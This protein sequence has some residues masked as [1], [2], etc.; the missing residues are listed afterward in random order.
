MRGKGRKIIKIILL[1]IILIFIGRMI[2]GNHGDF[3]D[4]NKV[5]NT[6]T[7]AGKGEIVVKPD[8]ANISFGVTAENLDV[9]KALTESNTKMNKIIDFLKTKG[10]DVKD[11]K[12]TNYSVYPRYDYLQS[13]VYPY[14]NGKQVLAAYV[15]SQSVEV[16]IRDLSK[17]GEILSGVGGLGV[18]DVSGLTFSVD[19]QDIIKD[20]ARDLAIKDAKGQAEVLAK[21]LGVKLVK[22]TGF[23]EGG[24]YPIYYAMDKV[25]AS[26]IGGA[27]VPAPEI[28]TGENKITSN[29]SI[30][31][32]IR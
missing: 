7:V 24:N 25:A 21:G 9:A 32:E 31:Y 11:I 30:T 20:Q 12:T 10:V 13:Q 5:I 2:F 6:I 14:N 8:I 19:N 15:I 4:N 18:T 22:I 27:S 26:G 3:R 29:V 16:K 17:A 1:V 28:L 23:S